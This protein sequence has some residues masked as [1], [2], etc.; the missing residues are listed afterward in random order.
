RYGETGFDFGGGARYFYAVYAI[1]LLAVIGLFVGVIFMF[2]GLAALSSVFGSPDVNPGDAESARYVLLFTLVVNVSVLAVLLG[3]A[4]VVQTLITNYVLQHVK[5]SG[6]EFDMRMDPIRVLWIQFS[7]IVAIVLSVGMLIP[8][9]RVRIVRYRLSCLS[10][11][12][13]E[14]LDGFAASERER[15][16]ATGDEMGE[17]LDLDLGL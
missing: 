1:A 16:G 8:W 13:S 5:L 4:I 15:L 17:A 14:P 6:L 7:N 12:A 11:L 10:V 2:G 3:T 9:A